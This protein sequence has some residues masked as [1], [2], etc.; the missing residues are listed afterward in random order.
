MK[1]ELAAE[2]IDELQCEFA[3]IERVAGGC[4]VISNGLEFA[5]VVGDGHITVWSGPESL[6]EEEVA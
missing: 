1:F 5:G 2:A 6:A 4:Q 3:I